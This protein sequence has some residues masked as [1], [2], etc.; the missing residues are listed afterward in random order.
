M[1]NYPLNLVLFRRELKAA[2]PLSQITF[3]ANT[4][5]NPKKTRNAAAFSRAKSQLLA[6]SPFIFI[7]NAL[8][9]IGGSRFLPR[10]PSVKREIALFKQ[11]MA[12]K[13]RFGEI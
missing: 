1:K 5:Y 12:M 10:T 13:N 8:K 9:T 6:T 4:P 2:A 7:K 3:K 11:L